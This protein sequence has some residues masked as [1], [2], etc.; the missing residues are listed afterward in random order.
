VS[1]EILW[2]PSTDQVEGSELDRYQTWFHETH[3]L[4]FGLL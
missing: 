1:G 3:G 4:D 2:S